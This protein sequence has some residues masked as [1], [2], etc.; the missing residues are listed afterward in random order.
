MKQ[1]ICVKYENN[2]YDYLKIIAANDYYVV[3]RTGKGGELTDII[4]ADDDF[5]N[6]SVQKYDTRVTLT[7]V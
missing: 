7:D 4:I 1:A 6:A 3:S 2:F 5:T